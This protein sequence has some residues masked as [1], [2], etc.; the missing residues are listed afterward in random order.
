MELLQDTELKKKYDKCK[1]KVKLWEYNF[2]K[3][4]GRV[5][6]KV[7]RSLQFSIKNYV[8]YLFL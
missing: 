1:Y 4:H 6:S 7:I 5:P 3:N 2:K 8:I